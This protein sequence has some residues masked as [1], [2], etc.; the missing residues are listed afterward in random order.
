MMKTNQ[1]EN[2]FDHI[3]SFKHSKPVHQ[4][5]PINGIKLKL[6]NSVDKPYVLFNI[7]QSIP[8]IQ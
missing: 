3:F 6:L 1:N 4:V 2:T 5:N 7:F 8:V